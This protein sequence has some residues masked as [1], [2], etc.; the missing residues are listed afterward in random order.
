MTQ[1]WNPVRLSRDCM[2][3]TVPAGQMVLLSGVEHEF[4]NA[5][6]PDIL[7]W[8]LV[9]LDAQVRALASAKAQ[10]ATMGS[11]AGG[12]DDRIIVPLR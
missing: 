12:G 1:G 11:V 4:D 6:G 5:A 7:T 10:L 8:S 2:A 3:T 9:F